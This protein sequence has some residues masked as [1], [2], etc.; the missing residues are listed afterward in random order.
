LDLGA[1]ISRAPLVGADGF[2]YVATDG[3]NLYKIELPMATRPN[4][5]RL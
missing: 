1:S 3:S 5:P 2:L 4:A